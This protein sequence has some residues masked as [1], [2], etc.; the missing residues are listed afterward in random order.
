MSIFALGQFCQGRPVSTQTMPWGGS[1]NQAHARKYKESKGDFAERIL[2]AAP[3]S[4]AACCH[5]HCAM[6]SSLACVVCGARR[7]AFTVQE[8][9]ISISMPT[10]QVD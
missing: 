10:R 2:R 4:F 6:L 5:R 8:R 7:A 3:A 1:K 9:L